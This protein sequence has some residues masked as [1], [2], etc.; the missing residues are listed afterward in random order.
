MT[1]AFEDFKM[2]FVSQEIKIPFSLRE[3]N[4]SILFLGKKVEVLKLQQIICCSVCVEVF[5]ENNL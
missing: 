4:K 3:H 2:I 5:Q 1:V